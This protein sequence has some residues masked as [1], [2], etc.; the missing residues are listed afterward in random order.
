MVLIGNKEKEQGRRGGGSRKGTR[1][2]ERK[3]RGKREG[4]FIP[5]V[6]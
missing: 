6:A 4:A 2:E 3:E 5:S 1:E